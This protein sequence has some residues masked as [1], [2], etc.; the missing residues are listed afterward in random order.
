MKKWHGLNPNISPTYYNLDKHLTALGWKKAYFQYG[1][2]INTNTFAF[3]PKITETLEFKHNLARLA[4]AYCPEH[5]PKTYVLDD[6]NWQ[7]M[8]TIIRKTNLHQQYAYILKPSL[9]NNGHGIHLFHSIWH[10]AEHYSCV[11]RLGGKHVLQHY[12]ANPHLLSGHKYSVRLFC[13]LSNYMGCYLYPYGYYNVAKFPYLAYDF[14]DKRPH[15]TNEHLSHDQA[16]VIQIPSVLFENF[17]LI[18]AKMQSILKQLICGLYQKFPVLYTN[19]PHKKLA[20]FGV[21]F[22]VDETYKVYLIEC[23]HRPC[24]PIDNSHPFQK[25]LYNDFWNAFIQFFVMDKIHDPMFHS[26]SS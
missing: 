18:Y 13:V 21:D 15:I 24:F 25:S 11:N 8:L 12:I 5:I 26:L 20:I 4:Q 19:S 2:S 3:D 9:L 17:P 23:N 22:L 14:L 6:N 7:N 10:I 16:N 1:T